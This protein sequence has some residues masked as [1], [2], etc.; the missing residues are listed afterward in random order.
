MNRDLWKHFIRRYGTVIGGV[1]IF[2]GFAVTTPYFFTFHNFLLILKQMSLLTI[3]SLGF[4]FVMAAGGFDMSIGFAMGLANVFLASVLNATGSLALAVLTAL[5]TGLVV[6]ALN[7]LLVAFLRLPDFIATFAVGSVTYGAKM[8]YSG[9][10]PVFLVSPPRSFF[11][12]GQGT[13]GPVPVPVFIMLGILIVSLVVLNRTKLGRHIYAIGGNP[14]AA[15]YAGINVRRKRFYTFLISGLSVGITAI[16]LTS[17]LGSGQPE[18]GENFLL[19]VISVCFLSTTMFGEGEPTGAGAF[20]GAFIITMLNNGLTM[21]NVP[22][23]VQYITKG[24]VVIFAV[25]LSVLLGQKVR[26]KFL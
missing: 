23:H 18:A 16:V 4:T 6:G 9:G 1:L 14:M 22:Y 19:D 20:V 5:G 11:T 2:I 8:L 17:R 24:M 25:M 7:G 3:V 15:L 12:I 21:L 10:Y 26:I 13:V